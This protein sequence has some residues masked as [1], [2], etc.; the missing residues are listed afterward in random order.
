MEAKT[1]HVD[2]RKQLTN[3]G[4]IVIKLGTNTVL[5]NKGN[6]NNK[7]I[8]GLAKQI[9]GFMNNGKKFIIISSGAIGIGNNCLGW[10]RNGDLTLT[11]CAASVGQNLLMGSYYKCFRKQGLV[12]SQLLLV[13]NDLRESAI[14]SSL[15]KQLEKL[16]SA[17]VVPIINENDA[18]SAEDLSFGDNDILSAEIACLVN[19]DLLVILSNIDGL[20]EDFKTKKVVDFVDAIDLGVKNSLSDK[21]S[22][23]GKGGIHSK[24][25]AVEIAS[26][27]SIK[28]V[29]A[30][31]SEKKV[32]KKILEGENIGT[33]FCLR[34]II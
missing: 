12:V 13:K 25:K 15:K 1:K 8:R 29:I 16:L 20:Y 3:A 26:S 4:L 28:T 23:L 30:N 31:G 10:E 32:I 2:E 7:I 22:R 19:A 14:K 6:F 5:D 17:G 21:T 11:R 34:K 24:I 27:S 33:L 9:K 18:L